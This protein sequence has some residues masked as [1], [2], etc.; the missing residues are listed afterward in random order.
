MPTWYYA[1]GHDSC[2]ALPLPSPLVG[3]AGVGVRRRE[4]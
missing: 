1:S 2:P 4:P 3:R